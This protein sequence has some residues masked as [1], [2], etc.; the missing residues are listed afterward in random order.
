MVTQCNH[1]LEDPG[2][3]VSSPQ[4]N[5]PHGCVVSYGR[6]VKYKIDEFTLAIYCKF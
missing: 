2:L 1:G 3:C 4:R 5:L 6:M